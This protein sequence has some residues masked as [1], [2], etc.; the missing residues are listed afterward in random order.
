MIAAIANHLWQ[1][2]LVG[3]VVALLTLAL[4]DNRAQVRYWLWL[5]ASVK[6]LAP[7]AVLVAVGRRLEWRSA[8]VETQ[9]AMTLFMD[10]VAQPFAQ[11]PLRAVAASSTRSVS[12]DGAILPLVLLA[13]WGAG[14]VL[15]LLTW[16]VRWRRLAA[17]VSAAPAMQQ[18]RELA[19]LRR[20]EAITGI[21][22]PVTM[23]ASTSTSAVEPGVFGI[24]NP[25]LLWPT[26]ISDRLTDAQIDAI[27]AH[28]LAHLRRRDNLAAAVHMTVQSVFW[29]HPLTWWIGAR[30][31]EER[32]RACDEEVLRLGSEPQAYAESLLKTCEVCI[33]MHPACAAG[34]TGADL[35]KRIAGIMSS[36]AGDALHPWKKVLIA[37]AALTAVAGPLAVGAMNAPALHAQTSIAAP[38]APMKF[39][40]ASV[41]PNKSGE[42]GVRMGIQPGGRFIATNVT[43]RQLVREAYHLQ[44]FQLTGGP[45]WFNVD[46]FDITAKAD[47]DIPD[48]FTG[49]SGPD[50]LSL[51]LRSLLQE[52]FKLVVH[53]EPREMPIYA[54][55]FA[56]SDK[57]FGPQLRK[58]AVD[59]AAETAKRGAGTPP[60]DRPSGR[61]TCGISMGPGM[62]SAGGASFAQLTNVLSPAVGRIIVDKTALAGAFDIDLRWTPDQPVQKRDDAPAAAVDPNGSSIFTALQEQL[63][64][65]LESQRGPVDVLVVDRAEQP[66]EN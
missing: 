23:V 10:A 35:K 63:G 36:H 65:K 43:L 39:E 1:S 41:K 26:T 58:A 16:W 51:L 18:G 11:A 19:A 48:P 17:V 9:P 49:S 34:V 27:L 21:M 44:N 4:R 57:R 56:R 55:L 7:F 22:T 37:T 2:T 60:L 42:M 59:C 20:L 12:T 24:Q 66:T 29:F 61:P 5:A 50:P 46:H 3:A 15:M 28:E 38:G 8:T 33:E 47:I 54:L 6:F 40:V 25:V 31:V 32:E 53:I 13:I 30:L 14:C 62:L 45:S 64:L 52:R